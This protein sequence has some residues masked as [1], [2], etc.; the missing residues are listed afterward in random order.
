[1]N[2]AEVTG[3]QKAVRTSGY[4]GNVLPRFGNNIKKLRFAVGRGTLHRD[5]TWLTPRSGGLFL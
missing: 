2:S 5:A 1:M 3:Q 4:F